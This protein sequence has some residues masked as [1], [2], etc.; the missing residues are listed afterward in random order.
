M[1]NKKKIII[2]TLLI[3]LALFSFWQ[4]LKPYPPQITLTEQEHN[5]VETLLKNSTPRCIGRYL[6]DLPENLSSPTGLVIL[7]KQKVETQRL[8]L[9]A[10][11]QRIR[12]REE[13]L[14]KTQPVSVEDAPFLKRVYPL[15]NG[16]KGIIFERTGSPGTPDAFRSLE[17]H[18]Y[19][20]GV[21][22]KTIIE[23]I[24]PDSPR[25]DKDKEQY[26]ELYINNVQKKLMEL[27][28]LLS[29]FHGRQENEVPEGTGLCI[30]NGFIA[31]SS[32]GDEEA[33]FS[34][35]STA[36]PNLYLNIRSNNFLQEETSMLERSSSISSALSRAG[37]GTLGKG[38]RKINQL[39]A[40]EWL[41]VGNGADASSGHVFALRVNE[42]KGSSATP[43]LLMELNHGPLPDDALSENEIMAFWQQITAT[44]RVRPG[45]I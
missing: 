21:A 29:K 3:I 27:T 25:Y 12:L 34:Y 5:V 2:Y 36:N 19:N 18:V 26:P 33:S 15:P 35:R 16:M 9:P 6:V 7:N 43:Y 41:M 13:E 44:L 45:A 37:G 39:V 11:E 14:R 24:N 30:P 28:A 10:F 31:G 1:H 32:Q 42:K 4:W 23:A 40:E 38:E 17:G 20:N 22:F 8:Y